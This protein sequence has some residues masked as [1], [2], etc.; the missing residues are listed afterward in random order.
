MCYNEVD[1]LL[2]TIELL[3]CT[4][5]TIKFHNKEIICVKCTLAVNLSRASDDR[6]IVEVC[7][8][9]YFTL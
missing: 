7:K 9:I 8:E 5:D 6:L 3:N 2:F 4:I 1:Q